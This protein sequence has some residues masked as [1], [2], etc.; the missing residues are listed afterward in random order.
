MTDRTRTR[1]VLVDDHRLL[2]DSL[3]AA[4]DARGDVAVVGVA[5]TAEEAVGLVPRVVPDV[6]L[7]DY[8][9]G[10][11]PRSAKGSRGGDGLSVVRALAGRTAARFVL[12]TGFPSEQLVRGAL[13]AGCVGFVVKGSPL[14][15]LAAAVHAAASGQT[16]LPAETVA[17]LVGPARGGRP[18]V[19]GPAVLASRELDV[20]GLLADGVDTAGIAD[21]LHLSVHTVRNHVKRILAKL[22]A[23]S[24]LEA[25]AVARRAGL[26]GRRP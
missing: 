2:L 3:R 26:V 24:R 14:D 9:L 5:T 18:H 10:D 19:A 16:Y 20:L 17:R 13:E 23:H 21:Q 12:V 25:V 7:V 6:V 15:E 4:L 8:D 11:S 22:Q 1:V